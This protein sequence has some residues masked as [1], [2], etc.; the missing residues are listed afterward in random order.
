MTSSESEK[1]CCP[2]CG[3][4][5]TQ[6]HTVLTATQDGFVDRT[7]NQPFRI[8]RNRNTYFYRSTRHCSVIGCLFSETKDWI[9]DRPVDT[10]ASPR[11]YEAQ[12]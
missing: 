8:D 6:W 5:V 11:Q 2:R 4:L 9:S 12:T 1:E 10:T 3:S 7:P